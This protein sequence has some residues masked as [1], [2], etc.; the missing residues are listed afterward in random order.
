MLLDADDELQTDL[1]CGNKT[2]KSSK[3]EKVFGVTI[4]NQL[5]FASSLVN[6]TKYAHSKFK[7]LIRVQKYMTTKQNY[8]IF[9]YFAKSYFFI[10][11]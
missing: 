5:N 6:I 4:D 3:Q 7:V 1:V 9:S 11:H 2:R 8:L 10:V